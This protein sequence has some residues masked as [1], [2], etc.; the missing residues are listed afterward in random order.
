MPSPS[1]HPAQRWSGF[2]GLGRKVSL[3]RL[4]QDAVFFND[5]LPIQ[6]GNLILNRFTSG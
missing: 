4:A 3:F 5:D 1:R 6:L 2:P